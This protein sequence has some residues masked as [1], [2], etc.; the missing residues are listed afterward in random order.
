M[1]S[2][3]LS[4]RDVFLLLAP[5]GCWLWSGRSS[6]SAEEQGAQHLAQLLQVTP[7]LLK[8]GEEEGEGGG[9]GCVCVCGGSINWA[10]LT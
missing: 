7:T 10:A 2:S 3:S 9:G 5:S 6:S 8:E 1:S 4:S